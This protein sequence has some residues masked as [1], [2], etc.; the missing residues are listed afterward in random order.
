MVVV[1]RR[2]IIWLI[3]AYIKK[4]GKTLLFSF[5]GGLLIFFVLIYASKYFLYLIPFTKKQTIGVTG[6]YTQDTLPLAIVN[7]LSKGLTVVAADGTIQPGLAASWDILDNGKTYQFHLKP[8]QHFNNGTLVTSQTI[9]Y[10]FSDVTIDRPDDNTIIFKLK[11]P[12]APFLVTVSRPIL[13]QGF[14]GVGDYSLEKLKLNGNFVQSMTMVGNRNKHEILEYDFYSTDDAL[15]IGY[16]LGEV[17]EVDGMSTAS[18]KTLALQNFKNTNTSKKTDY[19]QLITL[20]YKIDDAVLSDKKVRLALTYALPNKFQEGERAYLPYPPRSIYYNHDQAENYKQDLNHAKLLLL[21]DQNAS[22]S[23]QK[24]PTTLTLKTLPQYRQTASTIAAAWKQ[25]GITT[26]IEEVNTNPDDF[27]VFLGDFNLPNDP[28]QYT[29]WH[30]DQ[31]NNITHYKNLR[32]DLLLEQGRKNTA[33]DQR[34]K[35]YQDFQKY[36]LEDAPAAFLYFP[37]VYTVVRK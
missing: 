19:S 34:Q 1:R 4:S 36:L 27:Q 20:F 25:I 16:L 2:L 29:L 15:R 13:G 35:S 10:N 28:D 23:G 8:N 7:K 24:A 37:D 12:Y 14:V 33:V 26:K 5:L 11:D 17:T 9:N 30:S 21:P 31:A 18:S 6:A 22:N 32:I 3:K